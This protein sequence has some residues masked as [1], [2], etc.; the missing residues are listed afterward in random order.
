MFVYK[1]ASLS[2]FKIIDCIACDGAS[3]GA[4]WISMDPFG[5]SCSGLQGVPNYFAAMC[6]G[7]FL[8]GPVISGGGEVH[9]FGT[10]TLSIAV[11]TCQNI[12]PKIKPHRV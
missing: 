11:K 1:F 8:C 5:N 12:E 10:K 4:V 9:S 6:H 7:W 2:G 3:R